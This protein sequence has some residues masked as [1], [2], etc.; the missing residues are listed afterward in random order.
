[1]TEVIAAGGVNGVE[2]LRAVASLE[3]ASEHPLAGAIVAGA[4]E[5]GIALV[6]GAEFASVTGKGVTGHCG[7]TACGGG[8]WSA[9]AR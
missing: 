3:R 2:M 9:D 1:M 5:K 6:D 8:E 7:W 4:E